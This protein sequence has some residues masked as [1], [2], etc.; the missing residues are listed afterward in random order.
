MG[1]EFS[2]EALQG[3]NPGSLLE[4]MVGAL[5]A[6]SMAAIGQIE[7]MAYL[8]NQLLRDSDWASMD[9]SVELRTPLVDAWLLRDLVPVLRSFGRLKGKHMLA[10][11]PSAPLSRSIIDRVKTGFGIPLSA[12]MNGALGGA[13]V[14]ARSMVTQDGADSRR[15]ASALSKAVYAR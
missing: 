3:L 1:E 5:P 2:R 4:T 15:W 11:S 13:V 6:D 14:P 10:A 7:S 9:H 12:W 8:R